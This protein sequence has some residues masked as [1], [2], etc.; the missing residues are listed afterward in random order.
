M[1]DYHWVIELGHYL[2]FVQAFVVKI[3]LLRSLLTSV[4]HLD[5]LKIRPLFVLALPNLS[6]NSISQSNSKCKHV[7]KGAPI[8]KVIL[9]FERPLDLQPAAGSLHLFIP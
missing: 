4:D 3:V 8:L 7:S 6:S 5:A 1:L 2:D 9:P